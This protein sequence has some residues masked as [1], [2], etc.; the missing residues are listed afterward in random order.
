MKVNELLT[1]S[2]GIGA[3]QA[4]DLVINAPVEQN[5]Q[6]LQIII[7]VAIGVITLFRLLKNKQKINN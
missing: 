7:Q 2:L 5:S 4:T 3:V 1:G 6:L